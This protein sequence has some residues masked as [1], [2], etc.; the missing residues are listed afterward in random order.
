MSEAKKE[1][2]DTG[3]QAKDREEQGQQR[4]E[5]PLGS[6]L[7]DLVSEE[8]LPE[9]PQNNDKECEKGSPRW[10]RMASS[11]PRGDP[12]AGQSEG[13]GSDAMSP[14]LVFTPWLRLRVLH[15]TQQRAQYL[16]QIS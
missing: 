12:E 8:L 2:K 6:C 13:T 4:E 7:V 9:E 10:S 1:E 3:R 11:W 16:L 14:A 15:A 5:A